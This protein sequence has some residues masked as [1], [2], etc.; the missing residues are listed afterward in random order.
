MLV[1]LRA[2]LRVAEFNGT[3]FVFEKKMIDDTIIDLCP[4]VYKFEKQYDKKLK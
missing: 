3:Q 4:L 2:L 1:D